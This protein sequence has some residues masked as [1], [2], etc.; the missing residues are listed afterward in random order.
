MARIAVGCVQR[1]AAAV[2]TASAR[3]VS[4]AS[5]PTACRLSATS[6]G[7]CVVERLR[8]HHED[9]GHKHPARGRGAHATEDV[10]RGQA[11]A[12]RQQ[13]VREQKPSATPMRPSDGAACAGSPPARP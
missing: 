8:R 6:D 4:G 7:T 5:A 11:D 13:A 1:R 2:V 9:G 3:I 10:E 12:D